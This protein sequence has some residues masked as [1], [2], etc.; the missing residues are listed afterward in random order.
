MQLHA[1]IEGSGPRLALLHPVGLN[2]RFLAPLAHR[3]APHFTVMRIDLR[4]HG[5]SALEPLASS[6]AEFAD[7]VHETLLAHRFAPCAVAGF[8]FG[9]MTAQELAIRHP[10]SVSAL[11][12]LAGPCTFDDSLRAA[13]AMRGTDALAH[14]MDAVIDATMARWFTPEFRLTPDALAARQHLLD[15]DPRGWAQ[16]WLAISRLDTLPRLS[17]LR[18]PA[19]CVAGERDVSSTPSDVRKIAAAI[20]GAAYQEMPGAPHMLFIE[21]PDETAKRLIA[22]LTGL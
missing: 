19:L 20:P 18:I 15:S 14:G 1:V 8:S 12:A 2:G 9:S 22:F 4:G 10:A 17:E 11:I 5:E 21:Q 7:D 13:L 3:L 6:M 16:G